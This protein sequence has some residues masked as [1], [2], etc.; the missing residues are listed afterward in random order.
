MPA[1]PHFKCAQRP[2][3]GGFALVIALSLM[4]FVL[5]L[6]L[7]ITTLVQVETQGS[8][9]QMQQME[10]EQSAL[11]GLQ[12]ALGELQKTVGP[13]QRVTATAGI[14]N[15]S[16]DPDFEQPHLLGV[17]KSF[18]QANSVTDAIDYA[19]KKRHEDDNNGDFVQWL[20]SATGTNQKKLAYADQELDPSNSIKLV[21]AGTVSDSAGYIEVPLLDVDISSPPR[22]ACFHRPSPTWF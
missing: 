4:A 6:L 12:I 9:I 8:Q 7:S 3:Q 10:A 21:G 14:F 22:C 5:L 15:V 19:A 11:L 16:N 1:S 2:A 13:D 18:K 17:W 20:S